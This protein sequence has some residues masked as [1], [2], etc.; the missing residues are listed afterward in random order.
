MAYAIGH[1]KSREITDVTDNVTGFQ[2]PSSNSEGSYIKNYKPIWF[3]ASST[4]SVMC[5]GILNFF[6]NI[7]LM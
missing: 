4:M 7:S 2:P 3:D 1:M 6:F 5:I